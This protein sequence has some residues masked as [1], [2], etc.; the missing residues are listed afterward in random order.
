MEL[1][2]EQNKKTSLLLEQAQLQQKVSFL[3]SEINLLEETAELQSMA[4]YIP[5]YNLSNSSLYSQ[6]L[7]DIRNKQKQMLKDKKGAVC[8][9]PWKVNGSVREGNKM[10]NN[11]LKTILRAFNGECDACIGKC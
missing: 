2:F 3:N 6:R 5:K 8:D 4:F 11:S 1:K 7:N 9:I 10:T